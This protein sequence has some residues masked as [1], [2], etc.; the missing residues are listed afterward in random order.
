M[1]VSSTDIFIV[2]R[3]KDFAKCLLGLGSVLD[4]GVGGGVE[5]QEIRGRNG[6]RRHLR[7]RET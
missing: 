2:I 1:T 4:L 6:L 7:K 5:E 3:L